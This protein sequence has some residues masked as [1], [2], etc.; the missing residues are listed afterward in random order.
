MV[1][2]GLRGKSM[3]AA[4]PKRRSYALVFKDGSRNEF[5]APDAAHALKLAQ[6]ILPIG[7]AA[8]LCEDGE[9]LAEISYSSEG[10]WAVSKPNPATAHCYRG[11]V[12]D[13]HRLVRI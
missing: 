5:S 2:M 13:M 8:A 10:F 12:R 11:A 4:K 3:A 9:L 7:R 1:S 6:E